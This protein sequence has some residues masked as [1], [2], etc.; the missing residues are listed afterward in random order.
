MKRILSLILA[1]ITALTLLVG[2]G[3]EKKDRIL[4]S[5]FDLVKNVTIPEYKG[6]EVDTSSKDFKKYYDD[7]IVN[8]VSSYNLYVKKTEGKVADGDT[9]N[10]DYVGKKDGVA[11]EGGTA[12][13]YDL[14]IGSN[15]FIEGFE[16][17]LIDKNIGSTVD[18][19]LTFPADYQSE[20]LAGKA[21]VF[22]V[23]INYA[24][25]SE[26]RK[27]EDYYTELNFNSLEEY[28]ADV[29]DRAIDTYLMEILI[30]GSKV[31]KYS[32]TDQEFM[33]DAYIEA[34]NMNLQSQYGTTLETY[35]QTMGQTMESLKET[36]ITEQIKPTM[37]AQM[38]IY[39]VIDKENIELTSEDV[40]NRI[41]EIV[42]QYGSDQVTAQ[43]L[44]DYYGE[45]YFENLVATEK[46]LEIIR[47]NA[48]IK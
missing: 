30:K 11:F 21:V 37:D 27:P 13:G 4:Y 29:K 2:C 5:E 46:V 18:L 19:N 35:L 41:N 6:I 34:I 8:D 23:K 38:P 31:K 9:V 42:K 39:T 12:N 7:E 36:A 44:K 17:G 24:T 14:T 20:E 1:T 16:D 43:D 10:I 33:L 48:K 15:T 32:E 45:Y 22:T 25:T 3:T 40:E 47:E 28:E 26:E